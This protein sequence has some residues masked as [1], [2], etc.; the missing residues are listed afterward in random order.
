MRLVVVI[1]A[2]RSMRDFEMRVFDADLR[3]RIPGLAG[4]SYTHQTGE[5][6]LDFGEVDEG[7]LKTKIEDC[8]KKLGVAG[9]VRVDFM[10]MTW[11][12]GR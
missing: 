2:G 9:K 11:E 5:L 8:L 4:W 12:W 7:L 10:E 1:E 6:T 3:R